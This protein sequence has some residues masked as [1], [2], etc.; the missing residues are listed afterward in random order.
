MSRYK[1]KRVKP[2]SLRFVN[3]SFSSTSEAPLKPTVKGNDTGKKGVMR[4]AV[5]AA[6]ATAVLG[7]TAEW[8][9]GTCDFSK[10]AQ[11]ASQAF[12]CNDIVGEGKCLASA[13]N[14]HQ[15]MPSL[16]TDGCD[17][18]ITKTLTCLDQFW[19]QKECAR[20]DSGCKCA[21]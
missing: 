18:T 17:I 12:S 6:T 2:Q 11:C 1:I 21:K 4:F 9:F 5:I 20:G 10:A 8:A 16:C 15:A 3:L 7:A 14:V 19:T 13:C